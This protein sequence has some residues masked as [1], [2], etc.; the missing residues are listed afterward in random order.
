MTGRLFLTPTSAPIPSG[1]FLFAEALVS[2]NY[3][4]PSV[5]AKT[6]ERFRIDMLNHMADLHR[7]VEGVSKHVVQVK[8]V[9]FGANGEPGKLTLIDKRLDAHTRK[10]ERIWSILWPIVGAVALL[11]WLGTSGLRQLLGK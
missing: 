2:T 10:I 11:A 8:A 6:F 5:D 1:L 3:N 9:L 7:E 4:L